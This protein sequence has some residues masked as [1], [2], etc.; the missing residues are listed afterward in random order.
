MH[1]K[2]AMMPAGVGLEISCNYAISPVVTLSHILPISSRMSDKH[3]R[4]RLYYK[5]SGC[6]AQYQRLML[7]AVSNWRTL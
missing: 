7:S 6:Y 5:L 4:V 1:S 2:I 3:A